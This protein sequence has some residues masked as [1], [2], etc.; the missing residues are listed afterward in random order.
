MEDHDYDQQRA[1]GAQQI[2]ERLRQFAKDSD[3]EITRGTWNND[4]SLKGRQSHL[5]EAKAGAKSASGEFSDEQLADYPR[6][7][8]T[9]L[10]D[11]MLREMVRQLK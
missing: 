5:L 2:I 10:T 3:V 6:H 4:G 9:A 11:A 1:T 7:A 8:A